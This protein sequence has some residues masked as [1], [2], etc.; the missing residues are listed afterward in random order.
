MIW[1]HEEGFPWRGRIVIGACVVSAFAA[2]AMPDLQVM[3]RV[4]ATAVA[5]IYFAIS[6]WF[7]LFFIGTLGKFVRP[8]AVAYAYFAFYGSLASALLFI[9]LFPVV[10][11]DPEIA[12]PTERAFLVAGIL[13]A[14][15]G[16]CAAVIELFRRWRGEIA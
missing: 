1:P 13:P 3:E 14:T 12:E 16:V 15:F 11:F 8:A 9:A 6:Y 2:A 10:V 7:F 5:P 4:V